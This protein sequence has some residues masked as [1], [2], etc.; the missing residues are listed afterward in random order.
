MKSAEDYRTDEAFDLEEAIFRYSNHIAAD[1]KSSRKRRAIAEEYAA[2]IEDAV[3]HEMLSGCSARDAFFR[4]CEHLGEPMKLQEMLAC[5]HNRDP[6]PSYVKWLLLGALVSGIAALYFLVENAVLA[7]WIILALQITLLILGL[8]FAYLLYRAVRA[9]RLRRETLTKLRRYA[10]NHGLEFT[11]CGSGYA[12]TFQPTSRADVLIDTPE[13]RYILS[14]WGTLHARRHLHLTDV[15]L[16]MHS[17]IFGYANLYTRVHHFFVPGFY[18]ALPKGLSYFSMVHT[19][20][21]DAPKGTH[22]LPKVAWEAHEHPNKENVR[23]L[24]LSPVP[25]KTSL[26]ISG[27]ENEAFD[28]DPFLDTFVYS[29][30]GFLSYLNGERI[31]TDGSFRR[32]PIGKEK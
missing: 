21:T 7:A 19:E 11:V 25:F 28:G 4:V 2:H 24:L 10:Q 5:V 15:G 12:G 31:E 6:L 23:I 18:L 20:L 1:V 3:Y 29:T 16:Y 13:R 9:F 17:E 30:T 8:R 32:K 22:L 14:L 26:L 27:R